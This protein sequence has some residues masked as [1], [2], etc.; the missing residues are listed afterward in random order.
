MYTERYVQRYKYTPHRQ[1]DIILTDT[2]IF[3]YIFIHICIDIYNDTTIYS[4]T[5]LSICLFQ[6]Y[7]QPDIYTDK[8]IFTIQNEKSKVNMKMKIV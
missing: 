5:Y 2:Y 8:Q 1:A 6:L 7:M 3:I 4:D